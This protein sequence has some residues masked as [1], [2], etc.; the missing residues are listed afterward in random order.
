MASLNGLVSVISI[1]SRKI[2]DVKVM[3]RYCKKCVDIE[4]FK[5][6]DSV[7]YDSMKANHVCPINYKGSSSNME[8]YR[9]HETHF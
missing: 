6:S 5:K 8:V 3:S 7:K 2:I 4:K 1:D 9:R